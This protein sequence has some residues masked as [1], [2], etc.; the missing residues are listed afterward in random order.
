MNTMTKSRAA[1]YLLAVFLVGV[2]A[3]GAGGYAVG[4]RHHGP[5]QRP[6]KGNGMVEHL[7]RELKLTPEQVVKLQP[8]AAEAAAQMQVLHDETWGKIREAARASNRRIGEFLTPE[9]KVRLSV[10]EERMGKGTTGHGP[11]E[12]GSRTNDHAPGH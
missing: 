1:A 10:L 9:Q 6:E 5:P 4:C 11:G 12:S 7:T 8:I 2:V 3:G